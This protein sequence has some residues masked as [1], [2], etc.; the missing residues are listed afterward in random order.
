[1]DDAKRRALVLRL[2][3]A[4]DGDR[5]DVLDELFTDDVVIDWPQSGER[6]DG[7]AARR[8]IYSAMPSLPRARVRRVVGSGDLWVAEADLDYDGDVYQT[9]FVLEL[10]GD[11]IAR[12]T[13]YWAK[14]F[15]APESRARWVVPIPEE[16]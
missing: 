7:A 8:A 5:R 1:M 14:P 15:P 12:E 11:R 3:E 16:R 2:F 6:I 4:I 10:R 9:V 13:T